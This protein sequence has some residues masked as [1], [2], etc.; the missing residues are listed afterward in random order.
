MTFLNGASLR[1]LPPVE[2]KQEHVRYFHIHEDDEFDE[3]LWV[4][5]I[6]RASALPGEEVF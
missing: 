5:W 6:E 4:G 2:S 3:E 1:P